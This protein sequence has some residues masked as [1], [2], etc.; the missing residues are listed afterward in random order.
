MCAL[1][2]IGGE[3]GNDIRAP[4]MNSTSCEQSPNLEKD[5][6]G[7]ESCISE[8]ESRDLCTKGPLL[9]E[10]QLCSGNLDP[11]SNVFHFSYF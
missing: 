10:S 9:G 7:F 3:E 8:L 6:C 5:N 1:M 4:Q 11:P 2:K